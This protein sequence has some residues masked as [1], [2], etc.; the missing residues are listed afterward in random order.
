MDSVGHHSQRQLWPGLLQ[1]TGSKGLIPFKYIHFW[2][3]SLAKSA[4]AYTDL[5]ITQTAE[6]EAL[7]KG[8]FFNGLAYCRL[9]SFYVKT[10]DFAMI[11]N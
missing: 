11:K 1:T 3:A 6:F 8:V 4:Q 9:H 7:C 5:Y 10:R 2:I